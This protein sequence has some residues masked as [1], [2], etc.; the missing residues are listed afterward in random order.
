MRIAFVNLPHPTPVVRRYMCS[1]NSPFFLF[2]PQELMYAATAVR[3]WGGN[4]VLLIDAI[5]ENLDAREV[6][7]QLKV[8]D[9]EMVV[10]IIGFE[11]LEQDVKAFRFLHRE[12]PSAKFVAFGYYPTTFPAQMLEITGAD[13]VI[14]GEPEYACHE[15]VTAIKE[16][17]SFESILGLCFKKESGE[18][19]INPERP[20]LK[21][22]DELPHPDYSLVP[23]NAYS[24][25]LLPKPFAAIQTAR[26]CP[27]ACNYC[28]RSYGRQLTMRSPENIIEEIRILVDKFGVKSLRFADD[29]FTAHPARTIAICEGIEKNFPGLVWSCLSRIDTIDEARIVAMKKAGCKRIYFGVESGSERILQLYGKD[30]GVEKVPRVFDLV[31]QNGIEIACFFMVGHPEENAEDFE[32]TSK[33]IRRLDIDFATIGQT[34]PYPGTALFDQYRDKL[35]FSLFPYENEWKDSGRRKQ[36]QVWEQRFLREMYFRPRYIARHAW[37]LAA[38]PMTTWQIG[39]AM[40]P[41]VLGSNKEMARKELV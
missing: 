27:F 13:F 20:R 2:P 31:R 3:N 16:G 6:V 34:V 41:F 11:I 36:L 10:S 39:R 24:E 1:Y 14:L 4:E 40:L 28:T 21:P 5:A 38:N 8:F 25:F 18:V 32:Q 29:T 35:K 19:V 22:V 30:Y 26:G 37:R 15:L 7:N 23:I 9:A 12:L 33:L 17:S